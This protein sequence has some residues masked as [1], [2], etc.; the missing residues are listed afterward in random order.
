MG[1]IDSARQ[2]EHYDAIHDDYERHYYD[3][4][5]M[6]YRRRFIFEPLFEGLDLNGKR[7]ADLASGS[8]HNSLLLLERFPR[9]EVMGFDISP[10]AVEAYRQLVGAP[11]V[12]LDLTKP[13]SEPQIFDAAMLVGG[14]HHCVAD[15]PQTFA[16]IAAMLK[17]GGLLLIMLEPNREFCLQFVRSMWYRR[18]RYFEAETEEALKHDEIAALAA[19]WFEPR[20]VRYFGGPAIFFVLNSLIFRISPALKGWIT[21]P[22]MAVEAAYERLPGRSLFPVFGASWQRR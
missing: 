5:S 8:G 17:P 13:I 10:K 3:A 16:N 4:W 19:D 21:R 12:V 1:M 14:L 22:L 18:D 15:L 2:R 7:V 11:A 20:Q 9:A 6:D